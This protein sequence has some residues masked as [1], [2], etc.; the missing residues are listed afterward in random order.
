MAAQ[1]VRVARPSPERANHSVT[2]TAPRSP[3]TA[4]VRT[5]TGELAASTVSRKCS[6]M[7]SAD[8]IFKTSYNYST[9][10]DGHIVPCAYFVWACNI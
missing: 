1:P 4:T 6:A 3:D 7:E 2:T 9:Q 5:Y 8:Y 10:S